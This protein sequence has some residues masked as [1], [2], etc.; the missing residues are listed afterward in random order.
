MG[1][2]TGVAETQR[3]ALARLRDAEQL[4]PLYLAGGTAIAHHLGHRTSRD[5]DLFSIAPELDLDHA[6]RHVLTALPGASIVS[7][8]DVTLRVRFGDTPIDIVAYPYPLLEA[9][10]AGPERFPVAGLRDLAAMKL[11][12]IARRGLRRDFWDL[13][14][15]AEASVSLRDAASAYLARFGKAEADLYHVLRCLTYFDDA[16]RDP[17][18]PAGLTRAHWEAIKAYFR[19]SG[20]AVITTR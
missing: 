12:A 13:H 3:R 18:F 1:A 2:P 9:A 4:D 8:T 17:V 6:R 19:R 14:A 10:L 11:A 7:Q 20:P 15:I 5:L 16:E